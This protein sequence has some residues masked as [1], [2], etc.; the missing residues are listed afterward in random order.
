[1]TIIVTAAVAAAPAFDIAAHAPPASASSG[2]AP[3][4]YSGA[5]GTLDHMVG[6]SLLGPHKKHHRARHPR[7]NPYGGCL[8]D[9]NGKAT[10]VPGNHFRSDR[11]RDV[12]LSGAAT[13][14]GFTFTAS[15]GLVPVP[16]QRAGKLS[17]VAVDTSLS[18]IGSG[19]GWPPQGLPIKPLPGARLGHGQTNIVFGITGS[20]PGFW[21]ACRAELRKSALL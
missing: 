14:F 3:A 19:K 7:A 8:N 16:G 18:I 15:T 6:T 4:V 2:R 9:P 12:T 11:G 5:R 17:H 13:I 20:K 21:S 10:V 1:V